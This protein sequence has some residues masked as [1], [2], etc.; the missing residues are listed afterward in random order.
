M[1]YRKILG[2]MKITIKKTAVMRISMQPSPMKMKTDQKQPQNVEYFKY[3]S[4]TIT[5]GARCARGIKSRISMARAVFRRK[6]A[7]FT[8]KLD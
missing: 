1:V 6:H 8:G 5:N 3:Q 2:E 4:S 7:I